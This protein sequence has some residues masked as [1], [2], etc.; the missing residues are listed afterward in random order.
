MNDEMTL[1]EILRARARRAEAAAQNRLARVDDDKKALA[2]QE[3]LQVE[4]FFEEA[5]IHFA[6]NIRKGWPL[7]PVRLSASDNP[8]LY[9]ILEVSRWGT[10]QGR[11]NHPG[12]RYHSVWRSLARWAEQNGLLLH[13]RFR[14]GHDPTGCYL[15]GVEAL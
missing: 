13:I 14:E 7:Q 8:H 4:L 9:R 15:L 5:K 3:L 11:I 6:D 2:R 10:W 12:H 1:G